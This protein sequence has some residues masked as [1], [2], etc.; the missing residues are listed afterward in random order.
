MGYPQ[1]HFQ[2][3]SL[4]KCPTFTYHAI[5]CCRLRSHLKSM[6]LFTSQVC[7]IFIQVYLHFIFSFT[8]NFSTMKQKSHF[9]LNC[10]R[11]KFFQNLSSNWLALKFK[12]HLRL[13]NLP[14]VQGSGSMTVYIQKWLHRPVFNCTCPSPSYWSFKFNEF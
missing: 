11:P 6:S 7:S 8:L 1:I 3:F 13:A 5:Q 12:W 9:R 2:D 14:Q 4:W 10:W